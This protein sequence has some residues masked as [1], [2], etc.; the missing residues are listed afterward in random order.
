[1]SVESLG[2]IS[3]DSHVNE[4]RNL[5]SEN[6]PDSLRS[7]ALRGIK[8]GLDGNWEL[9]LE[10]EPL[11]TS[12]G[13]EPERVKLN[14]P[15]YRY[16]IMR[17]EG[18]V[19]EC[20]FPTVGL[21]VWQLSDAEAGAASCR[22]YNEWISEVLARSPRFKCAGL[23]PTWNLEDAL[24]EV[25][26]I[27]HSRLGALMLPVVAA[28]EWN[29][30]TWEPLWSA[31]EETELP[32]VMHQGTGHSMY[33]YRGAGAG[34]SNLIATQS[35]APRTAT[36][37]ATS[38]VLAR[39]PKLH[40]VL[41]E[42]NWGWLAWTMDTA[43]YYTRSFGD[44]GFRPAGKKW[45]DPELPEPPSSYIRRQVHATFQD[46]PIAIGNVWETGATPLIWGSDY[47]HP[48]GTYPHSRE[49]VARLAKRLDSEE[50]VEQIFRTNAA[51]LF[52]FSQEVL[53]TPV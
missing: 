26:W 40:V 46:D 7:R 5:W 39:H 25:A 16:E 4:P 36:L 34:V 13:D 35:M 14:D 29:H 20:I 45:I 21:Y 52:H 41:V 12:A 11:G 18:I 1:M 31:V 19:G 49:T 10:G 37:F 47:P 17:Q 27:A 6:L 50:A 53:T 24:A 3:A 44:E 51:D 32:V 33:F 2:F 38:G 23:V 42:F 28:P 22:I 9:V 15:E 43:D 8:P 48:E 30:R